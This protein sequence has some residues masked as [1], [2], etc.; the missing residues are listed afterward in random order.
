[1]GKFYLLLSPHAFF[2]SIRLHLLVE[3][4][5]NHFDIQELMYINGYFVLNGQKIGNNIFANLIA[6]AILVFAVFMYSKFRLER[7]R[8]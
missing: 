2:G 6:F 8:V 7:N 5:K 1:M 4:M 3:L